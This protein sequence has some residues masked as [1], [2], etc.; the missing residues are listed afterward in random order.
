MVKFVVV[1]T[2]S[3]NQWEEYAHKMVSSFCKYWPEDVPLLVQLDDSL[4]YPGS[5]RIVDDVKNYLRKVKG[6][7]ETFDFI[8]QTFSEEFKKF[9][10]RHENFVPANKNDYR[11]D[12]V[13]FSHK[14]FAI[15]A[16]L[17]FVN[18]TYKDDDVRLIWLDS[19]VITKKEVLK[20]SLELWTQAGFN[21]LLRKDW[22]HSECG[23]M[24]FRVDDFGNA[25][26]DLVYDFYVTDKV[27]S[28]LSQWHDSYVFDVVSNRLKSSMSLFIQDLSG[29]ASGR[30]VWGDSWLAPYMEHYKGTRKKEIIEKREIKPMEKK[31]ESDSIVN[32]DKLHIQTMNCMP[33]ESIKEHVSKNLQLIDKWLPAC[34]DNGE[35]VVICS[36]GPSLNTDEILPWYRKGVKIIAVKHAMDSLLQAGIVPW[37]CIL[38]DPRSHVS[39]F[40]ENPHPGVNYFVASMVD[41]AVTLKLQNNRI[42]GFHAYVGAGEEARVPQGHIFIQGGSA[43]ATRGIS[44]LQTLGFGKMHLYGYDCCYYKK[45]DL[46]EAKENGKLK[47]EE[48]TL[49]VKSWGNEIKKRTFWTEG[50]FLAQVNEFRLLSK[51]KKYDLETYGD[52]IIPWVHKHDRLKNQWMHEEISKGEQKRQNGPFIDSFLGETLWY[53]IKKNL[54]SKL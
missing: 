45:P 16:A 48:V 19:D 54:R 1:T 53:K 35:E 13:R 29:G 20:D 22:S 39:G 17:D 40:V 50:Q 47:F 12:Y 36:A 44:L 51:D 7:N 33:D 38:L 27:I 18:V 37:A 31:K 11:Y 41:P 34:R 4:V 3:A 6:T 43:T 32:L 9:L 8:S 26:I 46:K 10:T 25:L 52:G 23:F 14:V 15:K 42:F 24:G 49:E 21:T 5:D 28:E 30:D 2:F